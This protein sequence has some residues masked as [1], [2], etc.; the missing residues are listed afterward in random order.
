MIRAERL[1]KQYGGMVAVDHISFEVGKSEI[2]GFLGPNGAGKSTTMRILVGLL[3][4]TS[5]DAWVAGCHVQ[6]ESVAARRRL[7][8][9]PEVV[10]LYNEMTVRD[11]LRFAARLRRLNNASA[12]AAAAANRCSLSDR[13]NTH[14][15]K[16]SHGYRQRV[17]LAQALMHDPAVLIL[18]EPTTGLDPVQI[19]EIRQLIRQLGREHTVLVSTHILA[20]AEQLCDRVIIINNGQLVGDTVLRRVQLEERALFL[21]LRQSGP[22]TQEKL[23]ALPGIARVDLVQGQS[24]H[25]KL[26]CR[27]DVAPEADIASLAVQ[28]GWGLVE[29]TPSHTEL[30]AMFLQAVGRPEG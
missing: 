2:V 19:V 20:E 17:G 27:R 8:Y 7:G 29:L 13:L 21:R 30:E 15:G 12:R 26:T 11:Y 22:D 28:N 1:S 16:L 5:G 6:R 10:P 18:D 25:Y 3:A 4:P 23:A 9:V 14:I 24:D